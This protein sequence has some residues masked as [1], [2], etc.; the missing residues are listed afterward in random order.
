MVQVLKATHDTVLGPSSRPVI[1]L[2]CGGTRGSRFLKRNK[3]NPLGSL[4]CTRSSPI[5]TLHNTISG[6]LPVIPSIRIEQTIML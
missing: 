3:R 5:G 2:C 6:L 1:L 4:W